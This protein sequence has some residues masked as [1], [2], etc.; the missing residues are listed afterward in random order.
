M[1]LGRHVLRDVVRSS[2]RWNRYMY[3]VCLIVDFSTGAKGYLKAS[4]EYCQ[5]PK[6]NRRLRI[7]EGT[8]L[9]LD[10]MFRSSYCMQH[11]CLLLLH[12]PDSI[13]A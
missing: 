10:C 5:W 9:A 11:R 2:I 1:D 4:W 3:G 12:C 6:L 8:L 13:S 7:M